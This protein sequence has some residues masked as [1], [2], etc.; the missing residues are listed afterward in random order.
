MTATFARPSVDEGSIGTE[1][2]ISGSGFGAKKGKLLIGGIA[3]KI[4]KDGWADDQIV[5]LL[6]KV[7]P[8]G[9]PYDITITPYKSTSSMTLPGAF[10]V[11]TPEFVSIDINHG[12]PGVIITVYGNF[13]TTKKGKVYIED[14]VSGKKKS[15]KV[16][17]W[18][19][20]P[21][22]GDS[23]VTFIVPKLPKPLTP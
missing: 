4:A 6:T 9:G 23:R 18:F 22:N 15:C 12:Q 3:P 16:T 2:T 19:M 7:P 10:T 20:D 11:K 13:F 8:V 14:P 1:I 17:E 21:T 5:C